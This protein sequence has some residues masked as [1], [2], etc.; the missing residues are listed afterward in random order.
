ML[1]PAPLRPYTDRQAKVG[2]GLRVVGRFCSNRSATPTTNICTTIGVIN[3]RSK[4][5]TIIRRT[6]HRC[7]ALLRYGNA[8]IGRPKL[9][10]VCELWVVSAQTGRPHQ[11]PT[12]Y[13]RSNQAATQA[14]QYDQAHRSPMPCPAPL[15]QC[16]NVQATIGAG[17]RVVGRFCSNRSATPTTNALQ[18]E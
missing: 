13:N 10:L 4:P 9:E 11:P 7:Y 1:R 6:A 15:R 2:A 18:S 14:S 8:L 5:L 12:H 3:Q 16:T 17:L